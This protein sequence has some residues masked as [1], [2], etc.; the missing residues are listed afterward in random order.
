MLNTV[1]QR[2]HNKHSRNDGCYYCYY[3]Y[4]FLP[5]AYRES[6]GGTS[7]PIYS[8]GAGS[9]HLFSSAWLPLRSPTFCPG[10]FCG[11]SK[12]KAERRGTECFQSLNPLPSFKSSIAQATLWRTRLF[13]DPIEPCLSALAV[14]KEN[15]PIL[16][17]AKRPCEPLGNV[18]WIALDQ[19]QCQPWL[20]ISQGA[21]LWN[22]YLICASWAQKPA[23]MGTSGKKISPL[24]ILFFSICPQGFCSPVSESQRNSNLLNGSKVYWLSK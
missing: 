8:P 13:W 3:C 18:C 5:Q 14:W 2:A 6:S 4:S 22:L 9:F 19:V 12:P 20:Y 16:V 10:A 7:K 24:W 17:A 11:V 1:Q 23:W 21:L 15:F